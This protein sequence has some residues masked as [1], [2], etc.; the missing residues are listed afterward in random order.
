MVEN[1]PTFRQ[2]GF[3]RRR[4]LQIQE[5]VRNAEHL[6]RFVHKRISGIEGVRGTQTTL[7]VNFVKHDYRMARIVN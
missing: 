5:V 7:G 3:F 2:L 1:L 4:P 6:A